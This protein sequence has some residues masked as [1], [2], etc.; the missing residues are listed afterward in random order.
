MIGFIMDIIPD[1]ILA[2]FVSFNTLAESVSTVYRMSLVSTRWYSVFTDDVIWKS[3]AKLFPD[4][5]RLCARHKTSTNSWME[6]CRERLSK[7]FLEREILVGDRTNPEDRYLIRIMGNGDLY[8]GRDVTSIVNY[9]DY[10]SNTHRIGDKVYTMDP[11]LCGGGDNTIFN[12]IDLS[13]Y[14]P[15]LL[16]LGCDGRVM[17]FTFAPTRNGLL[18]YRTHERRLRSLEF[19]KNNIVYAMDRVYALDFACFALQDGYVWTWSMIDH[20]L[21]L[22]VP[23]NKRENITTTPICLDILKDYWIY[24]IAPSENLNQHTRMYYERRSLVT[25]RNRHWF[26]S[27]DDIKIMDPGHEI[28]WIDVP[29]I[30]IMYLISK[31]VFTEDEIDTI[32]QTMRNVA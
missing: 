14:D 13:N 18:F 15:F 10:I 17:E 25:H 12:A 22:T 19:K 23:E 21:P 27:I 31:S 6:L 20:P 9:I 1:E 2:K 29:N 7:V 8:F 4:Y 5:V 11:V 24:Q 3:M 26:R 30:D 32:C 16:I 28:R